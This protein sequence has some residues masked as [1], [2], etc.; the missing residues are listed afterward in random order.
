MDDLISRRDALSICDKKFWNGA[1]DYY[2][3]SARGIAD[4]IRTLPS[5]Q[6]DHNGVWEDKSVSYESDEPFSKITAWQSARCSKC[7]RYITTPYLYYFDNHNFCP[8]C[9][10]DMRGEQG[11]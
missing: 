3:I 5:A 1:D 9:G 7:K 8:Y 2:P 11:G 6:S 4:E 10:A